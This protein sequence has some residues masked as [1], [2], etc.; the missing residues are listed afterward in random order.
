MAFGQAWDMST[1]APTAHLTAIEDNWGPYYIER[2]RKLMDGTWES[3][4][5]WWGLK[6][7]AVRMSPFNERIPEDVIA[8]ADATEAGIIDGTAPAFAGPIK[9][10]AGEE[11]VAAGATVDDEGL[12]SMDWYVE[13]VQS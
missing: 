13:G 9:D 6:E 1:F 11:R 10:Q 3:G 7:G 8:A 4:D 12:L 5:T 2:I